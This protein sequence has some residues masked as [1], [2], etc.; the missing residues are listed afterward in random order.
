MTQDYND[1][2][3]LGDL[4]TIRGDDGDESKLL[5]DRYRIVRKLGEG[6][7]GLVYLAEDTELGNNKV[8]IKFIPPMLAGNVRA[9]KNLKKEAQ[10]AMQLSHPNIVRLHDLHTDGH[11]KFLAMEYIEGKTLEELLAEKEDDKFTLEQLMPIVEQVAAGLDYAHSKKVLHRD[12]KPS[13]IM[14]DKDG[15]AKLLDFGI[16]REIKDSYTRVTGKQDTS[17]TLPY[18]SP[19]Q[20]RGQLPTP[21]MDIYSLAAVL[22]ECLCGHPPFWTGDLRHQILYEKPAQLAH[23]ETGINYACVSALSKE[24][25]RRPKTASELAAILKGG[26]PS[27]SDGGIRR[28]QAVSNAN[29]VAVR[30]ESKIARTVAVVVSLVQHGLKWLGSVASNIKVETARAKSKGG[31]VLI[32]I[33]YLTEQCGRLLISLMILARAIYQN[34]SGSTVNCAVPHRH[35]QNCIVCRVLGLFVLSNPL[36][37]I[38]YIILMPILVILLRRELK[39]HRLLRSKSTVLA[40]E[41]FRTIQGQTISDLLKAGGTTGILKLSWPIALLIVVAAVY[42]FGIGGNV[43]IRSYGQNL[44]DFFTG[45]WQTI[46]YDTPGRRDFSYEDYTI[47]FYVSLGTGLLIYL[48]IHSICF[49][50]ELFRNRHDEILAYAY[51]K[52]KPKLFDE[53]LAQAIGKIKILDPLRFILMILLWPA[54]FM[55]VMPYHLAAH[56]KWE[57]R[58]KIAQALDESSG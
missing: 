33:G 37:W 3:T 31:K 19:E 14:V 7:M 18:M 20:L 21:S 47:T 13:N 4:P 10:T 1:S 52:E 23:I 5:A 56:Y 48:A 46:G 22:Y 53:K 28:P 58:S 39:T 44:E 11:Q 50:K 45:G 6:G 26:K 41:R 42:A 55:F 25:E 15:V 12:L 2:D 8:A 43:G 34:E 57:S 32:A 35:K 51:L 9:I 54:I 36:G 40:K 29:S 24:P 17:G 16:A 38:S 49:Y 27:A 30:A